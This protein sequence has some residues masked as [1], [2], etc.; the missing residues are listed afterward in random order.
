LSGD[1]DSDWVLRQT[2]S[3]DS[4]WVLS[5]ANPQVDSDWVSREISDSLSASGMLD[6]DAVQNVIDENNY[7]DSDWAIAR[8]NLEE[9]NR[10]AIGRGTLASDPGSISIGAT[11]AD[12]D[13][14]AIGFGTVAGIGSVSIGRSVID[15]ATNGVSIGGGAITTSENP[16]AI[17]RLTVA[18]RNNATAVGFSADVNGVN[19]TAIGAST[20]AQFANS[21]AIG[22]QARTTT[23]NQLML[24]TD[25][26]T[27]V[28]PGSIQ[29]ASNGGRLHN[30]DSDWV[31]TLFVIPDSDDFVSSAKIAIDSEHIQS[32]V[33]SDYVV[34]IVSRWIDSDTIALIHDLYDSDYVMTLINSN[35]DDAIDSVVDSDWILRIIN[36]RNDSDINLLRSEILDS[37]NVKAIIDS[38][39]ILTSVNKNTFGSDGLDSD[40]L[41]S[42]LKASDAPVSTEIGRSASSSTNAIAI[43]NLANASQTASIAIGANANAHTGTDTIALGRNAN[44]AGSSAIALGR[45]A[46]ASGFA[47]VAIGENAISTG[48]YSIMLGD[49]LASVTIWDSEASAITLPNQLTNK[50]YVDSRTDSDYIISR[51]ESSIVSTVKTTSNAPDSDLSRDG[52]LW[53]DTNDAELFIRYEDQW[54]Q[55]SPGGSGGGGFNVTNIVNSSDFNNPSIGSE[56]T[57]QDSDSEGYCGYFKVLQSPDSEIGLLNQIT[58]TGPTTNTVITEIGG[59]GR[60]MLFEKIRDPFSYN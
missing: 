20:Y 30:L 7:L 25:S 55:A 48:N 52:A 32:I 31:Q 58:T 11:S 59:R 36:E 35:I 15:Q 26:D 24:G 49:S 22:R 37:E 44:A 13:S 54:I 60:V 53:W 21:T 6:S 19:G 50:A 41:Y 47:S 5:V 46:R 18:T 38:D 43:G 29:I 2:S 40:T 33:D 39:Y 34:D 10:I 1:V 12:S 42:S 57:I 23:T 51:V 27:V 56:F 14:V 8:L 4:D 45:N 3:V 17:G 16:V 28:A 9:N